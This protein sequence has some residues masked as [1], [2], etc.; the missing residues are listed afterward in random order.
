[1]QEVST[2]RRDLASISPTHARIATVLDQLENMVPPEAQGNPM[3]KMF[4]TFLKEGKKDI[5]RMPE[6][7]IVALSRPIGQ[8]FTWVAD[9]DN[10]IL[11]SNMLFSADEIPAE[12]DSED[13]ESEE[14]DSDSDSDDEEDYDEED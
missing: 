13:E 9:G 2:E 1:M 4:L 14:S 11:D 8:A 3:V 6:E 5:R 12:S 7:F 10:S